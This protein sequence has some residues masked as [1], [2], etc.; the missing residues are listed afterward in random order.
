[1]ILTPE[2]LS[3]SISELRCEHAKPCPICT[4]EDPN[5]PH[6][7]HYACPACLSAWVEARDAAILEL[8]ARAIEA[9]T[10]PVENMQQKC[11]HI[12]RA[13]KSS[14]VINARR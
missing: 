2:Q 7:R 5:P 4:P 13:L 10:M 1:M 6:G 3:A 8:A 11:A 9:M 12:V 14:H